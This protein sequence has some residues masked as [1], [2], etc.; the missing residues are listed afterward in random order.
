MGILLYTQEITDVA[1]LA[2]RMLK[3]CRLRDSAASLAA[4]YFASE[5]CPVRDFSDGETLEGGR[6]LQ[7]LRSRDR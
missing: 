5:L 1:A 3:L 4:L 2:Q 6:S 7:M